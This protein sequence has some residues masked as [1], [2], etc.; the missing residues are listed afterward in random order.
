MPSNTSK[1]FLERATRQY[2]QDLRGAEGA[3]ARTYLGTIRHLSQ[4]SAQSFRLG[5]VGNPLSGHE[6]YAG[7]LAIPYIT[8]SGI[9]AMRFRALP[10]RN[11]DYVP[12]G[13]PLDATVLTADMEDLDQAVTDY[14]DSTEPE[15]LPVEGP[16]YLSASGDI[17]RPY[18]VAALYQ[19][20]PTICICEGELDTITAEQDG[21]KAI[22]IAG[23]NGWKPDFR[24]L[25]AGYDTV[26]IL[27]DADDKGQG[28][29][30]AEKVAAVLPNS[31]IVM[32][33]KGHDVNSWYVANGEGSVRALLEEKESEDE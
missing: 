29:G 25:F 24:H 33:P 31:R 14:M 22:G 19:S 2:Q 10:Q 8:A 21:L 11:P 5:Y 4:D 1:Q 23:V 27:A 9:V 20:S 32:M 26:F 16:K 6:Q 17:P 12:P 3:D 13:E 7:K 18:N 28:K 30:F 15:W